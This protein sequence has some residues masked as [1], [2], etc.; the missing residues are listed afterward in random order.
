MKLI[1]WHCGSCFVYS[2]TEENMQSD[3]AWVQKRN[4]N[5]KL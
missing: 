4:N 1:L 3:Y 2:S 5:E